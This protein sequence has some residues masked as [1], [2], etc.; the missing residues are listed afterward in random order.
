MGGGRSQ[1]LWRP[2]SLVLYIVHK[3]SSSC[4]VPIPRETVRTKSVTDCIARNVSTGKNITVNTLYT[5]YSSL[6]KEAMSNDEKKKIK[7]NLVMAVVKLLR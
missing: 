4:A 2:E 6:F 7:E 1:K 5:F 3:K